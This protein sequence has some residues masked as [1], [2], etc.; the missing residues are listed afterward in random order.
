MKTF[1][2]TKHF[3]VST[4]FL[5]LFYSCQK[6]GMKNNFRPTSN[7]NLEKAKNEIARY[8]NQNGYEQKIEIHKKLR[9]VYL[10]MA[11]NI[12]DKP[13][14]NSFVSACLNN[15]PLYADIVDYTRAYACGNGYLLAAE[16]IVSWDNNIVNTHPNNP[17]NKT[18]LGFKVSIPG[19]S[20]AYNESVTTGVAITDLGAD[21]DNYGNNLFSVKAKATTYLDPSIVNTPGA[22][23]RLS[24]KFVA[25]C[26]ALEQYSVSPTSVVGLG[27]DVPL[28]STACQR[29]DKVYFNGP[30]AYSSNQFIV[31]GYDPLGTCP[32]YNAG[33]APTAQNVQYSLDN[34]NNWLEFDNGSSPFPPY[35]NSSFI[36]RTNFLISPVLSPGTYNIKIRYVNIKHNSGISLYDEPNSTNSCATGGWGTQMWTIENWPGIVVP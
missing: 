26:A 36:D 1:I 18:T 13:V 17:A 6:E 7:F 3:I 24:A 21:P 16:W 19:N 33:V 30:G 12:V 27:Y 25:D 2:K 29:N 5:F 10:D 9:T 20:N 34:G 35:N 15:D 11:G 4:L 23:L 22:I 14:N 8:I 28:G 32:S 31:W